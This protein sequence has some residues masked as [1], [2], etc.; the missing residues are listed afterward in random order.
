MLG[1]LTADMAPTKTKDAPRGT[2]IGTLAN[3]LLTFKIRAVPLPE[4][5]TA[6]LL[7][8]ASTVAK[9][10][11]DRK[12]EEEAEVEQDSTEV[13]DER[14]QVKPTDF[15]DALA[16]VLDE[17]GGQWQGAADRIWAFGPKRVGANLLLDPAGSNHDR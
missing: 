5:V 1:K 14:L 7:A 13:Q 2:I 11:A 6:F 4:A 10:Q 3:Q 12:T 16:K 8:N 15:W 17:A 9:L